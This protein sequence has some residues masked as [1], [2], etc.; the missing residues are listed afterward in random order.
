MF[1]DRSIR[2]ALSFGQLKI[3][4]FD[5]ELLQPASYEMRLDSKFLRQRTWSPHFPII[6]TQNPPDDLFYEWEPRAGEPIIIQPGQFVLGSSVEYWSFGNR[7]GGSINGKSTLGRLGL[8]VHATAG[9]FDP[10]FEG[11][12]TLELSNVSE[13]VIAV[14]PGQKVAQMVFFRMTSPP[15]RLYGHANNHYHGQRGPTAPIV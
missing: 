2:V 7:I 10:G 13:H 15:T 11:N 9:F 5:E 3:E 12:A 6:D 1:S 4:P 8:Q 14:H